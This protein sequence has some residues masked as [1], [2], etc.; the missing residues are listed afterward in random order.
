MKNGSIKK[1][2]G[3]K[4]IISQATVKG[5]FY[6][7]RHYFSMLK[8]HLCLYI[9]L[10]SV[11]GHVTALHR[12]SPASFLLGFFVMVLSL[13]AG[14]LN[15]IQDRDY[16]GFFPR[17]CCR[18]LPQKKVP[19]FHARIICFVLIVCGLLGLLFTQGFFPF[20][21]G[22]M[23]LV[24]YNGLYT[25]LKKRSLLAIVPGSLCGM[26]PPLIG[27]TATG[28]TMLDP[29][30]LILMSVLGLWQIPHFFIVQL[31]P[32]QAMAPG[33]KKFPCFTR[34]FSPSEI[35]LQILI[36]TSLYSL[37][38]L[39]FLMKGSIKYPLLSSISALNALMIPFIVSM[40]VFN[41]QKNNMQF[42]FAA[43]NL[44]M[45][46]FMGAGICDKCFI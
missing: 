20:F 17:T 26:L 19:L 7:L 16:D 37:A 9:S 29:H 39:L 46:F 10:C 34:V 11:L 5:S 33:T 13:G 32:G 2:N 27:W 6:P 1:M 24:S 18:S 21:W 30:I 40:F 23:A 38:I 36:W 3:D 8:L 35:K 14:V 4:I 43:I 41:Q 44:S 31:K 28:K 22:G 15:N 12:F 45:L 42:A 25:P